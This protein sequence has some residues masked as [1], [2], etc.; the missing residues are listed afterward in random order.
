MQ[1]WK[2]P[3][4]DPLLWGYLEGF[5]NDAKVMSQGALD[6][7]LYGSAEISPVSEALE[8]IGT[9]VLDGG[10]MYMNQWAG[11]NSAFEI[12]GTIPFGMDSFEYMMWYAGG[13]GQK[14]MDMT[15]HPH[16]VQAFPWTSFLSEIGGHSNFP[17][18]SL[19]DMVGKRY[20]MGAGMAQEIL[21]GVGI[22]PYWCA[23]MEIYGALDRGVVDIIKWG[24]YNSNWGMKFHEVASHIYTP[25]WQKPGA[26]N[27]VEI[28]LDRYNELPDYLK[29]I[30]QNSV[31]AAVYADF[32]YNVTEAEMYQKFVDYGTVMTKL[33][34]ASLQKLK[35]VADTVIAAQCDA[36][37]L[38]K[39]IYEDQQAFIKPI[40]ACLALKAMPLLD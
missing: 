18:N 25:G 6:I 38:F 7:E 5:A 27:A 40:R 19:E 8:A 17:I 22:D 16:N 29:H 26:C 23:G 35:D 24:G 4:A 9:G 34:V 14:Y 28:N 3:A 30:V 37:P 11:R 32:G 1:H 39:E 20:R 31:K 21:K 2:S 12:L 10:F 15:Y 13:N 36:N 33:D